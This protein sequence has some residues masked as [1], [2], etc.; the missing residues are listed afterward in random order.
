L[1]QLI[2]AIVSVPVPGTEVTPPGDSEIANNRMEMR[3]AKEELKV[4]RLILQGENFRLVKGLNLSR[5][6]IP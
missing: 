6:L 1:K 2:P 5:N 4:N 3:K